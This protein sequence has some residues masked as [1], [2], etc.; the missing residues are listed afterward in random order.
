MDAG[1]S[2][3]DNHSIEVLDDSLLVNL[4]DEVS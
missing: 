4:T 1:Q 2:D 3:P